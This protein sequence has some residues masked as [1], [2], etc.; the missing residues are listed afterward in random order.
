MKKLAVIISVFSAVFVG[1]LL[2]RALE[3]KS[4]ERIEAKENGRKTPDRVSTQN[5]E[6]VVRLDPAAQASN[7]IQVSQLSSTKRR[8]EFAATA[9][10]L[11]LQELI[12]LRNTYVAAQAQLSKSQSA[13]EVSRQDYERLAA[14]YRE[15]RNASAKAFQAAE[16]NFRSDEAS[17]KAA[18]DSVYLIASGGRQRWGEVVSRWLFNPTPEFTRLVRQQDLL[19]QITIPPGSQ[20]QP[21]RTALLQTS[22]HKSVSARLVSPLPRLDPRI[23]SPSYLY[24]TVSHSGLIPGLTIAVR[25]PAGPEALGVI[26]PQDA[27]VWWQGKA[28]T[29]VQKAPDQFAR[30]EIPVEN[31]TETGW[32]VSG[33]G[34]VRPEAKVVVTGGQQLLSEEFRSEI[35]SGEEGGE[36]ER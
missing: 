33:N 1:V 22:L 30:T 17:L 14:L 28:W 15:D 4:D 36:N 35:Q 25:L 21:P 24:T 31:P 19:I 26:V 16:G 7:G 18:Q 20:F 11:P 5:G 3:E 34:V 2:V 10:V 9:L 8:E 27:I 23:Q 6:V 12:D 32:F 13:L 29:Y